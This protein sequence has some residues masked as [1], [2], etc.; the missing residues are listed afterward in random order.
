MLYPQTPGF[1]VP[2]NL[3]DIIIGI[4]GRKD[5]NRGMFCYVRI[6]AVDRV[7]TKKRKDFFPGTEDYMGRIGGRGRGRG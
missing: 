4:P 2:G 5:G 7:F 1:S 6:N 3:Q